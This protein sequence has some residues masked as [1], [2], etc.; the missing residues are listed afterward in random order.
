MQFQYQKVRAE[1]KTRREAKKY[2]RVVASEYK[3]PFSDAEKKFINDHPKYQG[4]VT[5]G[6]YMVK[7][8]V[9]FMIN[10]NDVGLVRTQYEETE[11]PT[12]CVNIEINEAKKSFEEEG[13]ADQYVTMLKYANEHPE[14]IG[15]FFDKKMEMFCEEEDQ[16]QEA[17]KAKEAK[18][19]EEEAK[20]TAQRLELLEDSV[21]V[22]KINPGHEPGTDQVQPKKKHPMKKPKPYLS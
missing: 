10:E 21:Q 17:R 9:G 16:V 1:G 3:V 14:C 6:C 12:N 18:K 22:Q 2:A 8:F 11:E 19:K 15:N 13:N 5:E 4:R 7:K 20:R